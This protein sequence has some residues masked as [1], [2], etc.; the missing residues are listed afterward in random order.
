MAPE[1]HL[2]KC[3]QTKEADLFAAA[4]TLFN[5]VNGLKPFNSASSD[6][7]YYKFIYE[8]SLDMFWKQWTKLLRMKY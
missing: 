4:V 8:K 3:Y 6:D 1:I 5:I 2:N 7:Y